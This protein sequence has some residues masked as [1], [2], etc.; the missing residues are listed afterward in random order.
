M[1]P[2]TVSRFSR[3]MDEATR[4][5]KMQHKEIN[6]Y[7][8]RIPGVSCRGKNGSRVVY[9]PPASDL[10]F[11]FILGHVGAESC[12]QDFDPRAPELPFVDICGC[13]V[14]SALNPL[15]NPESDRPFET[16]S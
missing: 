12:D 1:S 16:E 6:V 13:P 7:R 3:N 11:L 2:A 5:N 9:L 4:R 14:A 15:I 8:Y 10:T